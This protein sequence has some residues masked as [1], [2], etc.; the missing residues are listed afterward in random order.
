MVNDVN[1]VLSF[2]LFLYS[3]EILEN[4]VYGVDIIII[5]VVDFDGGDMLIYSFLGLGELK[6]KVGYIDE[7]RL[8]LM[9]IYSYGV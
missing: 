6:N 2:M 1:E 5:F 8:I 4:S 9:K 7:I 3:G